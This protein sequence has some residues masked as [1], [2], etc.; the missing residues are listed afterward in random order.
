MPGEIRSLAFDSSQGPLNGRLAAITGN[1]GLQQITPGSLAITSTRRLSKA[2]LAGSGPLNTV[3]DAKGQLILRR[4]SSSDLRVIGVRSGS[5]KR[6]T[7][8]SLSGNGGLVLTERGSVLTIRGGK[9]LDL[10]PGG[11]ELT[12]SPFAGRAA[13]GGLLAVTRGG[14]DLGSDRLGEI[15]DQRNDASPFPEMHR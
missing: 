5:P 13:R 3:V 11:S 1:R 2:F 7:V 6:R 10:T 8:N 9:L 4:G 14:T 12:K 15:V